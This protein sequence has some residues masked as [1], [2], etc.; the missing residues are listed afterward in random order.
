MATAR[1]AFAQKGLAGTKLKDDILVPAGIAAGS[2]YYQFD[3]KVELLLAV[4]DD[5]S[6]D[7]RERLRQVHRPTPGRSIDDMC[8]DSY[9]LLFELAETC[10]DVLRIQLKE[11]N[12]PEPRVRAYILS[13]R[14][15][16]LSHLSRDFAQLAK[17]GGVAI[18]C[19]DAAELV[20]ALSV[21]ALTR[22]LEASEDERPAVRDRLLENLVRFTTGGLHA[23]ASPTPGRTLQRHHKET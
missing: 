8:R 17:A 2:F 9:E 16:W 15:R 7:Y 13:D 14:E 6:S 11:R 3:D 20:V 1:Q 22:Y 23:L 4:L 18:N 21:G 5:Y 12:S 19:D 10:T